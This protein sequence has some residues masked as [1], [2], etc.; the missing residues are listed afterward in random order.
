[1]VEGIGKH[2]PPAPLESLGPVTSVKGKGKNVSTDSIEKSGKTQGGKN[3]TADSPELMAAQYILWFGP[4]N[5]LSLQVYGG[6]A[7]NKGIEAVGASN[8]ELFHLQVENKLHEMAISILDA[9]GQSIKEDIEAQ[10]REEKS[11]RRRREDEIKGH[12][13][14]E[15]YLQTLTSEQRENMIESNR[16][17]VG[18]INQNYPAGIGSDDF[19]TKVNAS[20]VVTGFAISIGPAQSN[21]ISAGIDA[22]LTQ[23]APTYSVDLSSIAN[24]FVN[25]ATAAATTRTVASP[26]TPPQKID[27]EYAKNYAHQIVKEL[28]S[29]DF[30]NWAMAIVTHGL[31]PLDMVDEQMIKNLVGKLKIAML[32]TALALLYQTETGG[33]TGKEFVSMIDGELK[34]DQKDPKQP[35]IIQIRD[36]LEP[37]MSKEDKDSILAA[38]SDWIDQSAKGLSLTKVAPLFNAMKANEVPITPMTFSI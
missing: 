12:A 22:I 17:L 15:K 2:Q 29:S 36:L 5:Q 11:D 28:S 31:N 38:A 35:L 33:I 25:I 37:P 9:W 4:N 21:P 32:T 27:L 24:I 3:V 30:N 23:A 18:N 19:L 14:F 16:L 20:P 26:G 34:F 10:R 1:M 13:G 6:S 7:S 8:L